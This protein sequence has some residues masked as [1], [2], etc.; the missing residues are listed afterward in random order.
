LSESIPIP[1]RLVDELKKRGLNVEDIVIDALLKALNVD[2]TTAAGIRLDI[3]RKYLEEGEALIDRD[4]VQ[5]SEKLYKACEEAIKALA[6]YHGLGEILARVE[7]R[8]R[9]T[10]TEL[11][12]AVETLSDR[13][14]EWVLTSWDAAWALHVWGFHEARLD[15]EAVRR[16]AERVRRLITE[17][18]R[19]I[20]LDK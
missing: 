16:R 18:G 11:E 19:M 9:W 7:E 13:I 10:V 6:I 8:G 3:A 15:S 1:R 20:G 12:K 17:S 2:P 4:P 5:A 14:G